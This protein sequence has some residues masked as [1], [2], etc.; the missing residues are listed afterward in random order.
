M[1]HAEATT[2]SV[3]L[4][5]EGDVL[6]MIVEDDGHGF[7]ADGALAGT[8]DWGRFGLIGM[9]ERLAL[10]GGSL[11]IE[12]EPGSGTTQPDLTVVGEA[13]RGGRAEKYA[14]TDQAVRLTLSAVQQIH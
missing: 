1:K 3:I 13:E 5:R 10:V 14:L 4:E 8:A 6:R 12:S 2:A 11:T 7:D 9:C